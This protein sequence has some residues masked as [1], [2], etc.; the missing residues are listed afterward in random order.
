MK[1]FVTGGTGFI[2][3]HAVRELLK[4]GHT[5]LI[6]VRKKEG[7]PFS[8]SPRLNIVVGDL[9]NLASYEGKLKQF[10]PQAALH[11]AWGGI[12]Q[13]TLQNSLENVTGSLRLFEALYRMGCKLIVSSGSCWEYASRPGKLSEDAPLQVTSPYV[14]AKHF[15][16][17]GG[18]ALAEEYHASFIWLRLFYV[19][20]PGQKSH[21]LIPHVMERLAASQK[22]ELKDPSAQNDFIYVTDVAKA[23][24]CV[25]RKQGEQYGV[26]NV[27]S[28]KLTGVSKIVHILH[29]LWGTP[30]SY[31]SVREI[32]AKAGCYAD[33]RKI[34]R[35]FSWRAKITIREGVTQ[36]AAFFLA[37]KKPVKAWKNRAE[38]K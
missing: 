22:I 29:N 5:L 8:S 13:F 34:K 26:Y 38:K 1:I 14:A 24:A 31:R 17:L 28:G 10:H 9:G 23:I 36:T 20:G 11:L 16:H 19:Y 21:S 32:P 37:K 12:P 35:V 2:G 3:E 18:K 33:T 6:L 30:F 7:I 4:E 27:G 15:V 25:M